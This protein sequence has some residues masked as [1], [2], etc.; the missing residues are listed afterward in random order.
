MIEISNKDKIDFLKNISLFEN[1]SNNEIEE[2]ANISVFKSYKKRSLIIMES[3]NGV[4]FYI[5]YLGKI[6]IYK[7][8]SDG[9][10]AMLAL[11]TQ[12]EFFGEMSI[13]DNGEIIANAE[14][15]EDS[16]VL[17]VSKQDFLNFIKTYNN[18]SY[19]LLKTFTQRLR[20]S[21][22]SIQS[23]FLDD[24]KQ[25]I[26]NTM[27]MLSQKIGNL[28][29]DDMVIKDMSQ[30][31]LANLSG[32]TRETFSRMLKKIEQ[33]QIFCKDGKKIIIPNYKSFV[34]KYI[35]K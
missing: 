5:I 10:E 8:N 30:S 14:A 26:F 18:F 4:L 2:F 27:H 6:K 21:D 34:Q 29:G 16:I 28:E 35:G 13:I 32:T 15:I 19:N 7:I 11:L 31:D 22:I 23:L 3:D 24:V 1:S 20:L 33:E 9:N 12:N 25:R 17:T